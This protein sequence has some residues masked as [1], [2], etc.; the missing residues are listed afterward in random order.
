M[1]QMV[2]KL[3]SWW[4]GIS[5]ILSPGGSA[6]V[7]RIF[8]IFFSTCQVPA[9]R[10][11]SGFKLQVQ[12]ASVALRHVWS[13]RKPLCTIYGDKQQWGQAKSNMFRTAFLQHDNTPCIG[14]CGTCANLIGFRLRQLQASFTRFNIHILKDD[15]QQD[16]SQ[17]LSFTSEI[18]GSKPS[19]GTVYS[20]CLQVFRASGLQ[21]AS[22]HSI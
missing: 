3:V 2:T 7:R 6:K 1:P 21:A 12:R 16:M 8:A 15:F 17:R 4:A 5:I 20:I 19:E 9:L 14:A 10:Q 13:L 11:S 22:S 18:V